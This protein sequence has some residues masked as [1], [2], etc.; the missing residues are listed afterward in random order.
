M[1]IGGGKWELAERNSAQFVAH[2]W[3]ARGI[4]YVM[5]SSVPNEHSVMQGEICRTIRG[6]E[7]FLVV[8]QALPPMRI[9]MSTG[10]HQSYGGVATLYLLDKYMDPSSRDDLDMLLELYPDA[11]I[12]FTCFDI[13]VGT[14]PGRN[15]IFWEVRNY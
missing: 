2:E 11:T 1:G 10:R 14:F 12:E 5:D 3:D 6:L 4:K 7:S 15:T 13:D 9:T 8:G